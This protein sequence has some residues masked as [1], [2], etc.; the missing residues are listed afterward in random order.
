METLGRVLKSAREKLNKTLRD[1]EESTGI[2]NPYLSQLEND[3]IKSTL[4]VPI[5]GIPIVDGRYLSQTDSIG[6][7]QI[8]RPNDLKSL[9][10]WVPFNIKA[11]SHKK[12][13]LRIKLLSTVRDF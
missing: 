7:M 12:N 4:N 3:K 8:F 1:V 11:N 10:F 9:A 5:K 6:V 13:L 2:S